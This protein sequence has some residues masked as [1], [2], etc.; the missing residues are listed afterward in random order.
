M[1]LAD[2]LLSGRTENLD[3][4]RVVLA[5]CVIVSHA[6]PLALGPGTSEPL[7]HLTGRSLGGWAVLMF[8]FLSGLLITASAE[9]R[10]SKEFWRARIRRIFPGLGVALFVTLVL[11][12]ISGATPFAEEAA[13]WYFRA[14]TLVSIEH[15]IPGAF[16]ANP[17]PGVVN[18]PLWSLFHEVL[19]YGCCVALVSLGALQ[20]GS[21]IL[22]L[23]AV[24]SAANLWTDVMPSRLATFLPLLFAFSLGMAAFRLQTRLKLRS[25][26]GITSALAVFFLPGMLAVLAL[27]YAVLSLTLVT[28]PVRTTAD[29]SYGFYIY[30]WPVAQFIVHLQ[31]GVGPVAL[32]A[33]S[34]V[35]TLPFAMVSWHLVERPTMT[36]RKAMVA[37]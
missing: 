35:L 14:I 37:S 24:I 27:S 22:G 36:F 9:R 29:Y 4:L 21:H 2:A 7:E 26:L 17:Y 3:L 10:T 18:G 25:D 33:L 28:R 5:V 19:A 23:T 6:W 32:A 1:K 31:P 30:G 12:L 16:A 11:A 8:F 20:R 13:F 15:Q 34:L